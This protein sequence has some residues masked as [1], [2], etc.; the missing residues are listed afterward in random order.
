MSEPSIGS[1]IWHRVRRFVPLFAAALIGVALSGSAW[2]ATSRREDQLAELEFNTRAN[3][4]L[5][6][7]QNGID[8]YV[9][10]IVAL[11]AL[12]QSSEH[13]TNRREFANF[14]DFLLNGRSAI[15]ALSWL[16]RVTRDQRTAFELTAARSGLP[17]YH[18]TTVEPDGTLAPA[19]DQNEYFP[20]LYSSHESIGSPVYGLDLNDGG[21][22]QQTLERAR[23]GDRMAT[24]P[25]FVLHS[26]AGD[27]NGFF[28][29]L[30]VYASNLPHQTLQDRRSNL[31]GFVEGVFQTGVLIETILNTTTTPEGL[32]LYFFNAE[33]GSDA[34]PLYFHSSGSRPVAIEAFSRARITAGLHWTGELNPGDSWWTF[35]AAPSLGGPGIASHNVAWLVLAAGLL[36]SAVAVAYIWTTGRFARHL[37]AANTQLDA[38]LSNMS[39]G[40][41][42]FDSSGRLML[43]NHRYREMYGSPPE[44]TKPG[45]TIRDLLKHRQRSGLFLDD[46]EEYVRNLQSAMSGGAISERLVESPDGRTISLVNHPMAGGGW[47]A[48]YEDVTERRRAEAKISH[49]ALHD[50]LTNLPNRRFFL[51]QIE[52]RLGH[53]ERDHKFAVLC[54]D[55]DRFKNVNDTLGHIFGD[56]LLRQVAARLHPCLREG[57]AVARMGGD[58]FAIIQGNVTEATEITALAARLIET[59]NAPFDLDGH[60]VVVGASIGIAVAPTD[61]ADAY[62]LLKNADM[63]LYRAKAEGRGTYRFFEPKMDALMQAR[64]VLE[65]DLRKALLNGE[66]ELY[67]QPLV[68][69][70]TDEISAFE[71]LLRWNHPE[72]GLVA[73]LE[74]I[75][76]AEETALIV[77]I[78]EW[79]LRQACREA[80]K[81][82]S[83]ISVAVNVS[84][85]QFKRPNLSQVVMSAL[86]GSGLAAQR[87]ELEI[88]ES[89]LLLGSESTLATLHQLRKMGVRISMDD[90]GTGYSSLSY[91]RSFPFDKI[92]IDR[93]FVHDVSSNEDSMAIIRA[94]TGL[95]ASL[96]MT[97]TGE[98]VET[99]E[100]LDY[101][102]REGCIEAQGYFFSQPRPAGEVYKMLESR[103]DKARSVA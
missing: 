67:Y 80:V 103:A 8:N 53:L 47:V 34:S 73:P 81:W 93:S 15:L 54:F 57:D 58:E 45:C 85:A 86:A 91:L 82:P 20:I 56:K 30:P 11:R 21:L 68:N 37:Q 100:E 98:G 2:F 41:C 19:A 52:N 75:S 10:V 28:V 102:K 33:A 59:I 18:I 97:T 50:E 62:Q 43:S 22:R 69:L 70:G 88:T 5:L 77:P 89:V 48:T 74:F 66:F 24:S 1:T 17:G 29:V 27:R 87:L 3:R 39:Q 76:L 83:H 16:P 9:A 79:V 96:R 32:D 40:L 72:R 94:V 61:A 7:L 55:L 64:R 12:F 31:T 49:M 99:Q 71:A 4:N 38:A 46:P 35:I 25:T 51:E 6:I 95:G 13:D 63:A 23:D 42:M 84:P 101:L 36:V 26:G 78:G 14:T 65:L 92:K 90:F 44:L 60:H